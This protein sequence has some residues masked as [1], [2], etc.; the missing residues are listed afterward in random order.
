M[1]ALTTQINHVTLEETVPQISGGFH[2]RANSQDLYDMPEHYFP[3][4]WH[5][6]IELFYV[7]EG[8]IEYCVPSG[9]YSFGSG[10]IG[11]LNAGVLHMTRCIENER[12]VAIEHIFLPQIISGGPGSDIDIKYVQPIL[13]SQ[14]DMLL[15]PA[16]A[17]QAQNIRQCLEQS[18]A[19]FEQKEEG[20]EMRIRSLMGE[21]WLLML[22]HARQ[23][24]GRS[25]KTQ[26]ADT[27][28]IKAMM[29]YIRLHYSEKIE[30]AGIAQAAHIG[31]R[32][33][34]RCFQRQLDLTPF[35]YVTEYRIGKACELLRQTKLPVTEVGIQCG[36]AS[37]SYFGKVFREKIGCSPREYRGKS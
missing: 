36:F 29:N 23:I 30:L 27:E 17:P 12:S 3:W 22:Q 8:Q 37:S 13:Q 21:V 2:Y 9:V 34:C 19:L 10:D 24:G 20:F 14:L 18:L 11:F 25:P 35:E 6:E 4:H 5:N 31:I 28:R 1:D 33:C 7:K 16:D 26:N 15:W 32:E